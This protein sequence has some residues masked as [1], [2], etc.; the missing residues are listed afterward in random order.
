MQGILPVCMYVYDDNTVSMCIGLCLCVYVFD[1]VSVTIFVCVSVCLLILDPRREGP[2][3]S[4]LLVS[5]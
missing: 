2:M 4:V 3:N 1:L 5:Q